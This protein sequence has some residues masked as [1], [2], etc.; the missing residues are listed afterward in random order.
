MTIL[1]HVVNEITEAVDNVQ[2]FDRPVI[3]SLPTATFPNS[4]PEIQPLD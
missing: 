3:L 2:L 1:Q 4:A